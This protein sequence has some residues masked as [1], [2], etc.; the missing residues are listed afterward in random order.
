MT[1]IIDIIIKVSLG[2]SHEADLR[3]SAIFAQIGVYRGRI[4]AVKKCAEP[5]VDIN[6][7]LKKELKV[8]TNIKTT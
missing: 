7:K 5:A 1:Y 3:F 8:S 4:C 2:S 6:R